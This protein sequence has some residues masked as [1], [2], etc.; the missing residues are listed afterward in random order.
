[1]EKYAIHWPQFFTATI[2][3]W[4]PILFCDTNKNIIVQ[5]LKYLVE[6]RKIDLFSFVIMNNH[7]HLI[8]QILP[9]YNPH[10]IQHSFM[11]FT[12]QQIKFN[13]LKSNNNMLSELKVDAKDRKYQIWERNPLSV[14]LI[15][16]KRFIQKMSYIHFNPV[17]AKMCSFPEEYHYSSAK[18]YERGIDD[19]N[20]LKSYY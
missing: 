12:A 14:D 6:K 1:M 16:E 11:K 17:K 13:L 3:N 2:L 9:P 20:L 5:S 4:N 8:W 15:N 10:K 19:F 7:I 18:F